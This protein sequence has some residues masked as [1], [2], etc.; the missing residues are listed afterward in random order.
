MAAV[1]GTLDAQGNT[2]EGQPAPIPGTPAL[3]QAIIAAAFAAKQG[4]PPR[5]V[6]GPDQSYY[7]LQ[8]E[9]VI[10]PKLKPFAEVEAQVREDWEQAQRRHEQDEAAAKLMTAANASGSLDD[11][12]TVAGLRVEKTPPVNRNTPVEH[13]P[14]QVQAALFRL[15]KG[16]TTMVDTPDGF[17]VVRLAEINEPDPAAD[18]AGT[19]QLQEALNR[20]LGAD[21]QVVFA[22]ALRDRAHP[23]INRTMLDN[24]IE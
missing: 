17:A 22:T 19:A 8:V 5:E 7:A 2:P 18:P 16:E 24:L 21:V 3:R 11:A 20:A 1:T 10:E 23:R 4:D 14:P 12:A 9:D 6:E 13:V 15:K